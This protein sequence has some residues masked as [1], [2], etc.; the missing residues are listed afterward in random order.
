MYRQV[1]ELMVL[2][3]IMAILP[4][5]KGRSARLR[6]WSTVWASKRVIQHHRE[7]IQLLAHVLSRPES[8]NIYLHHRGQMS[9][10]IRSGRG[11]R[12]TLRHSSLRHRR[13]TTL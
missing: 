11:R 2:Y 7:A 1:K 3:R 6:R 10:A 13:W 9:R 4:I 5:W 8:D 12:L